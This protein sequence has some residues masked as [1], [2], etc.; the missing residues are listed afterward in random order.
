MKK[1]NTKTKIVAF[2]IAI[3]I[4][5][6]MII[7]FTIGLNFDLRYQKAQSIQLYLEKDFETSDIKQ[8]TNEILSNQPVIIQ[9]VEVYEDTV[10]IIA[11]EITEEQ[12]NNIINKVNEKYELELSADDIEIT[13][14]PHTRGRDIVR[15][16]VIP[17]II[18]TVI[19]L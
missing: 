3:I 16:Y 14:L 5:V 12:K 13:N 10:N 6:G 15:P 9:K 2:L 19:I 8:I 1:I 18:A 7:T 4:I 17:F 11:R